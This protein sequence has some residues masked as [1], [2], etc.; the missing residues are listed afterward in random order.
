M[1]KLYKGIRR[2]IG[3]SVIIGL[4]MNN[5]D[6]VC[7][8]NFFFC[9]TQLTTLVPSFSQK[10]KLDTETVSSVA[11]HFDDDRVVHSQ[12]LNL[13]HVATRHSM[14]YSTMTLLAYGPFFKK[15]K[16]NYDIAIWETRKHFV[17]F[18]EDYL[19]LLK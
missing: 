7:F 3:L 9:V 18:K 11:L 6:R 10:S 14:I 8:F 15:K 2:K 5:R 17:Y 1:C 16:K 12:L 4:E 13:A 19:V